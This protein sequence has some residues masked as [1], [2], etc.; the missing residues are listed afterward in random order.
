M[1]ATYTL[2][3][4]NS[5]AGLGSAG[6]SFISAIQEAQA[7]GLQL[8]ASLVCGVGEGKA[9]NETLSQNSILKE[10]KL[11]LGVRAL[12]WYAHK[13]LG[14]FMAPQKIT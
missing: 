10:Q 2:P 5:L 7:R 11:S 6:L 12:A 14:L 4:L 8:K 3:K 13:A 9:S 1:T